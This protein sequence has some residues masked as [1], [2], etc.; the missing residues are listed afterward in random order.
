MKKLIRDLKHKNIS[1]PGSDEDLIEDEKKDYEIILCM[2]KYRNIID[3]TYTFY[4]DQLKNKIVNKL[5][6]DHSKR[7]DEQ[8]FFSEIKDIVELMND[9]TEGLF[10]IEDTYNEK[11]RN[12]V[13]GKHV[14]QDEAKLSNWSEDALKLYIN[15]LLSATL[16]ENFPSDK[17]KTENFV[18]DSLDKISSGKK[19][20][21]LAQV[22]R[23]KSF[24]K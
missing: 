1:L 12:F 10:D 3:T 11:L 9:V 22:K 13:A 7:P 6:T 2:D 21:Y 23:L 20:D 17:Y 4:N 19:N 14:S 18:K 16:N 15:I 8:A 5:L 24:L